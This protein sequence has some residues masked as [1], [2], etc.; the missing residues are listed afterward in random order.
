M[1]VKIEKSWEKLLK[2]EF[3]KEYF[4][5]LVGFVK[6]EYSSFPICPSGQFIF[7]AFDSCPVAK[8]KVVIIGQDPYHTKGVANGLA[9]SANEGQKIPPSLQ[10]IYKEISKEFDKPVSKSPD[11]SRWAEQGVLL[12]NATL[13]VRQGIAGSHQK[14]GWETFTDAAIKMISDECNNLVFI[15]WGAYAQKKNVLIDNTKHLILES[16]HPSPFSADKGFFGNG[17]FKKANEYLKSHSKSS[18]D[19]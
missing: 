14:H 11:L 17:H 10:N 12:L 6:Q 2:D 3:K 16:H 13:T 1:D 4:L 9:F 15:L 5:K 7:K 18:I 19:W 8:L